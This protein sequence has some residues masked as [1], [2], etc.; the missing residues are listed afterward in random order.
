MCYSIHIHVNKTQNYLGKHNC[1]WCE[2]QSDQLKS[3]QSECGLSQ[4][5]SLQLLERDYD[6]FLKAGGDIR[7][8]K[9]YFSSH[10]L[11]RSLLTR[12]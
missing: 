6:A 2:I 4:P 1:L 3:P 5:R 7:K 8:V 9:D 10:T 12:Y 11:L